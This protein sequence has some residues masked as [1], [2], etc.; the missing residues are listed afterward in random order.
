[1]NIFKNLTPTKITCFLLIIATIAVPIILGI[2][3][4]INL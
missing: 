1:M 2:Y 3:V 4:I